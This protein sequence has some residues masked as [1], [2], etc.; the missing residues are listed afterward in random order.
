MFH[1]YSHKQYVRETSRTLKEQLYEH[2]YD[3]R[4]LK[5]HQNVLPSALNRKLSVVAK[6][7]C[8]TNHNLDFKYMS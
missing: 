2:F 8:T 7:F 5:N 4:N 1:L 6:H 3:W